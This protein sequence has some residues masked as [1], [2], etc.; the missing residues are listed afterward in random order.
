MNDEQPC[1]DLPPDV[2]VKNHFFPDFP[3]MSQLS[4]STTLGERM[5][6]VCR[7]A[8]AVGV[9]C[10]RARSTEQRLGYISENNELLFLRYI[11]MLASFC[12]DCT[13]L[14]YLRPVMLQTYE[15]KH[16]RKEK[17]K[18]F[19]VLSLAI[20]NTKTHFT[21]DYQTCHKNMP[22]YNSLNTGPIFTVVVNIFLP[23][24]E[25]QK[26]RKYC[27]ISSFLALLW[28]VSN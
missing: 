17:C 22:F 12:M 14:R 11:R 9:A 13:T 7:W 4:I 16:R 21:R 18:G 26:T 2:S 8:H 28:T 15:S 24:Y 6:R 19:M 1:P 25:E 3:S 23:S 20:F 10:T 5:K 27:D